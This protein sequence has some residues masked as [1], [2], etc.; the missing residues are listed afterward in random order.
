MPSTPTT[1]LVASTTR[2]NPTSRSPAWGRVA[3][4]SPTV[5][6][7]VACPPPSRILRRLRL[8]TAS[9]VG[10]RWSH[11]GTR[12]ATAT[13]GHRAHSTPAARPTNGVAGRPAASPQIPPA[14]GGSQGWWPFRA[15]LPVRTAAAPEGA[16]SAQTPP[17]RPFS[18]P[19][20]TFRQRCCPTAGSHYPPPAS[21]LQ[22]PPYLTPTS[23]GCPRLDLPSARPGQGGADGG[24]MPPR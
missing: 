15:Q 2:P 24:A 16:F 3:R 8:A 6:A 11:P 18:Y 14:T 20:P 17:A 23:V 9:A 13:A 19:A 1:V 4:S 7:R 21:A 5:R 22:S 12:S 10:R